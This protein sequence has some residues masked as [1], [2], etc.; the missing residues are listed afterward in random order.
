M[1]NEISK[2]FTRM[3]V[4]GD[5]F[6]TLSARM[7]THMTD[8]MIDDCKKLRKTVV[9]Y[10]H[11]MARFDG[12]PVLRHLIQNHKDLI[13]DPRILASAGKS[14]RTDSQAGGQASF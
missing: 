3:R 5:D 9:I 13:V 11:N 2:S 14:G 10:Y 6:P 8:M 1:I 12:F 4:E 7:L